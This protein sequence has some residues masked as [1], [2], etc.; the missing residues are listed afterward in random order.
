LNSSTAYIMTH[1]PIVSD[2]VINITSQVSSVGGATGYGLDS[3]GLIPG[4]IRFFSSPQRP[5]SGAHPASYPVSTRVKRPGHE[6]DYSFSSKAEA[7][8]G[9]L[10]LHSPIRF[11]SVVL[12]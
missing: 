12:N 8:N 9:G 10:Y 1:W 2:D 4:N 3:P 11:H 7:K 6:A 5:E